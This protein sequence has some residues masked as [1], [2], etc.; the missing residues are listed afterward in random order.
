MKKI[1]LFTHSFPYSKVGEAFIGVELQ[2]AS[3]LDLDLTLVP[4]YSS[5]YKKEIPSNIKVNNELSNISKSG[6]IKTVLAML[7]SP[8]FIGLFFR[9]KG[10]FKSWKNLFNAVKYLYGGLLIKNFILTNKPDFPEN[11]IFYSFWLNYT[12]LGFALAK[13]ND[14]HLKNCKFYS[15]A[16]RYD[17]YAEE[18][19]IFMP[20]REKMLACLDKVFSGSGD[21]VKFLSEKYPEFSSKIE[22]GRLGVL[23]VNI[24]K[25]RNKNKDLSL[26]SCSTVIPVKRVSMIFDSI[27]Q[28]C[29]GNPGLKVSWIHIGDG[30]EMAL[31]KEMVQNLKLS[32]LSVTL[33]G[34]KMLSE[35]IALFEENEYDAFINLSFSEGLPV[36]LMMAISAGIPLI[37]TD[38]GG[39]KEIVNEETGHL[40][41]LSFNQ[42]EFS[43][44]V[45]FCMNNLKLRESALSCFYNNF[46]AE[47]NYT[48]FYSKL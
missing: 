2:I 1:F 26:I 34:Y 40:L 10:I 36:T 5:S 44:A 39:S 19:G 25:T 14:E 8:L 22:L 38:A 32:N 30:T 7:I 6:K 47:K 17:L 35:I 18:V 20:Y 24:N 43:E 33:S 3:K 21:G 37:A 12:V 29:T 41:P 46:S 11:S 48:D 27:K 28:F 45:L 4:L 23:P 42:E 31:L 13:E 9:N 16:H 15:R